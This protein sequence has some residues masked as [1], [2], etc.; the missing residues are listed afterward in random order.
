MPQS[1]VKCRAQ[2]SSLMCRCPY[3]T[4]NAVT[5]SGPSRN[6]ASAHATVESI[7]PDKSTTCLGIEHQPSL[8]AGVVDLLE[9]LRVAG[10][11]GTVERIRPNRLTPCE[12]PHG[13]DASDVEVTAPP[14]RDL[15]P[16]AHLLELPRRRAADE[17]ADRI[18]EVGC[19]VVFTHAVLHREEQ[20]TRATDQEREP[21]DG[22]LE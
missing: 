2:V 17:D 8:A 20:V 11:A 21:R 16:I 6:A 19:D 14:R 9:R 7:P 4:S 22:A 5:S 3:A 13:I 12:P 10:D 18:T 15:A 1:S